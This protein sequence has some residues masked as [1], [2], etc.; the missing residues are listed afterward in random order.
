MSVDPGLEL[1]KDLV[2]KYKDDY[3]K[4]VYVIFPYGEKGHPLEFKKTNVIQHDVSKNAAEFLLGS[5]KRV[6]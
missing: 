1:F 2:V 6:S 5:V 3:C 4:L